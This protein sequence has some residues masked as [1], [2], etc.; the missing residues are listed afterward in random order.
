M[1]DSIKGFFTF[2]LRRGKIIS[3]FEYLKYE[4]REV[5][6]YLQKNFL[7]ECDPTT[8]TTWR[9]GDGTAP[10]YNYIYWIY[11][12]F[13]ENDFYRSNQIREGQINREEAIRMV[14]IENQP[15]FDAI[16]NYC[17]LIDVDYDF[18]MESLEQIKKKSLVDNWEK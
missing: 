7:W 14:N 1:F 4:E 9:I 17:E 3:L 16:K 8:P 13:T 10:V 12:G 18:V 2:Y 15:R 6:D 11:A 5:N